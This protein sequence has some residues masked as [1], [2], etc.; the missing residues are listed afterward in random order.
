MRIRLVTTIMAPFKKVYKGFDRNLFE[1]LMP[2]FSMASIIRYEG[3]TPGDIIDLKFNVPF[4]GHWTVIIKEAH[5][6]HR[7]YSFVDRGLRV[8]FG[9]VYWRHAHRVVARN[10]KSCFII[11]DIEYETSWVFLDY[12]L[13][14]PLMAIFYPRKYFYKRYYKRP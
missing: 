11:D 4:L 5:L 7:E 13:Y 3:Q 8:P 12:M 1:Y 14:L 6:S 10:N 9:I 2:P